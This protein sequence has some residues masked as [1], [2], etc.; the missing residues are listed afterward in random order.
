MCD[1]KCLRQWLPLKWHP[2]ESLLL[3]CAEPAC[4][5]GSSDAGHLEHLDVGPEKRDAGGRMTGELPDVIRTNVVRSAP[6]AKG[7]IR[8]R[9]ADGRDGTKVEVP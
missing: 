1:G 5:N 6:D 8:W 4:E 7:R 2:G 9:F 3:P